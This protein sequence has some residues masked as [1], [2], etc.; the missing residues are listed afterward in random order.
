MLRKF[1]HWVK[2]GEA[3]P[4]SI[5]IVDIDSET[6]I[7]SDN[8]PYTIQV[9]EDLVVSYNAWSWRLL[10]KGKTFTYSRVWTYGTEETKRA[11]ISRGKRAIEEIAQH[12]KNH[13][14]EWE[15]V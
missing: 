1:L 2:T 3:A 8:S 13:Q 12:E 9:K 11:A 14:Q 4:A 6:E 10:D 5:S 7:R 15:D